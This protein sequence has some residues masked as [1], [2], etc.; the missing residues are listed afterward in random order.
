VRF[1]AQEIGSLKK[2]SW[3]LKAYRGDALDEKDIEE[4]R[5][6][7]KRL[8]VDGYEQLVRLLR[9]PD[10]EA[11]RRGVLEWSVKYALKFFEVAGLD[12][13][14]TGEQLRVEM[15]E[16][17]VRRLGGFRFVGSI[18]S[19]NY[20]YYR[21]AAAVN[22]PT[23]YGGIYLEELSLAKRFSRLP[24]K[25][26]ITGP[27]TLMDWS[28]LDYYEAR[29]RE[30]LGVPLST[31]EVK[32]GAREEFLFDL[33][34]R[35]Y[36][37]EMQTILKMG[38]RW[39]Q[40][41][42]PAATTHPWEMGT[43]VEAIN[44]LTSGL[45]CKFSLHVCY[46]DYPLLAKYAPELK[47]IDMLVI[48]LA[49]VDSPRLGVDAEARRGYV[50]LKDFAEHGYK[51]EVGLGVLDVHKSEAQRTWKG[52]QVE[53]PELVRDRILFALRYVD[54]NKLWVNPDCGGRRMPWEVYLAKLTNMVKGA[55]L[56][57]RL[58]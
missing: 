52:F 43:F 3:R 19:F 8:G 46:S 53:S 1:R 27:Y 39:I 51:G 2:P 57:S 9:A 31:P 11:K 47:N 50:L 30:R 44:R 40:I 14:Y 25:V 35:V 48:A 17:V 21:R 45:E 16:H 12:V 26:P 36:R 29:Q 13:A 22:P 41:D 5:Y 38:A 34:D 23:Y 20:A 42:E 7:G 55:E 54:A 18:A 33:I 28:Y 37:P 6:W 49:N 56:A 58:A 10:S 4:A 24:I 15:Y 32:R